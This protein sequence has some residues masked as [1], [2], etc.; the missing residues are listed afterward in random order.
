MSD[1]RRILVVDDEP[2]I[3]NYVSMGLEHQ[4]FEV[5]SAFDGREAMLA[6]D[7]H[8]PHL[9]I[10]DV[11]LPGDDGLTVCQRLRA[12]GLDV[13]VLLLT[14]R[15]SSEDVERGLDSGA[16]AYLPKPFRLQE[17]L[18]RVRALLRRVGDAPPDVLRWRDLVLDRSARQVVAEGQR[19]DLTLNEYVL[20]ELLM[21]RPTKIHAREAILQAVW[22][23]ETRDVR[24][25]K[26][27]VSQ[28]R[29]RLGDERHRLIRAVRGVGYTLGG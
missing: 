26:R 22:G 20:L 17:L 25:L 18:A 16:D 23:D 9:V 28:L 14:A 29:V 19:I 12:K 24:I 2:S 3:V 11:M 1:S 8:R 10:L 15:G 4:G 21:E 6:V 7:A 13:P 27:C 5:V